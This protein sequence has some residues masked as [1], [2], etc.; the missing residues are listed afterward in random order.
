MRTSL[1][2]TLIL[3]AAALPMLA[4]Q[5]DYLPL[6]VGNQWVYRQDGRI[7]AGEPIVVD[8]PRT[9]N[10]GSQTYYVVRGLGERPEILLRSSEEGTVY[11]YDPETRQESVW[12]AFATPEGGSYRT[13]VNPCNSTAIV[14]SRNSKVTVPTGEFTGALTITYPA[15]N[16]ADAGLTNDTFLPYIGLVERESTTIAGP[17]F[18]RL[19]YARVGGVTVLSQPEVTFSLTLDKQAYPGD[20]IPVLTARITLRS[21]QPQPLELTFP[22]S[23]RYDILIRDEAGKSYITWSA[24]KLFAM[25]FGTEKFGPGER[26]WVA[27]LPLSVNGERLAAGKYI[28]EAF[29]ATQGPKRYSATVEFEVLAR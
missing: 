11:I 16:C 27:E 17:R 6:H 9:E 23:Q 3:T 2:P 20:G 10:A 18:L 29:L 14:A 1:L 19:T 26:N 28:A 15:A 22:S 7:R 12:A 5:P 13:A 21:T 4:A 8:I 25:V 24:D